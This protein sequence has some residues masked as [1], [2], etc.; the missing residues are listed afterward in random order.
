MLNYVIDKVDV[1]TYF[2]SFNK[3]IILRILSEF[4]HIFDSVLT[5]LSYFLF[6]PLNIDDE[7]IIVHQWTIHKSSTW[8][9][10][11]H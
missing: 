9:T 3:K 5:R 2:S 10:T 4:K 1:P 7:G 8:F 11:K 6:R